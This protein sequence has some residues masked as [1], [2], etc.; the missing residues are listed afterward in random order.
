MRRS[1]S[2]G[3][4][5]TSE[6]VEDEEL[7]VVGPRSAYMSTY[8]SLCTKR[9]KKREGETHDAYERGRIRLSELM[10]ADAQDMM[11]R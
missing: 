10:R 6:A 1:Q 9:K 5:L 2:P 3:S 11:R 7:C 8:C 4:R